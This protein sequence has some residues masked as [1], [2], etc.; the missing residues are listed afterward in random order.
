MSKSTIIGW[1][2]ATYVLFFPTP[3]DVLNGAVTL[4]RTRSIPCVRNDE[5]KRRRM[6]ES[7][8]PPPHRHDEET[9]D[10]AQLARPSL[11]VTTPT[12]RLDLRGTSGRRH[13][14]VHEED[15]AR[16]GQENGIE[17][18]KKLEEK[19]EDERGKMRERHVDDGRRR[20][21]TN[22]GFDSGGGMVTA[23]HDQRVSDTA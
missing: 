18:Y 10:S 22:D 4:H 6:S 15:G 17:V 9:V 23:D 7:H 14:P 2:A 12:D 19:Q 16:E 13:G 21:G 20:N 8:P 3:F 5:K 1:T 11:E